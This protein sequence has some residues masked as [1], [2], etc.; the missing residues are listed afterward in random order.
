M[1]E[2]VSLHCISMVLF[3][4]NL[5]HFPPWIHTFWKGNI[6]VAL[7]IQET[8][9]EKQILKLSITAGSGTSLAFFPGG[10]QSPITSFWK[11]SPPEDVMD[12]VQ[13]TAWHHL[14][15]FETS[16]GCSSICCWTERSR[17]V[18]NVL[19]SSCQTEPLWAQQRKGLIIWLIWLV[20]S[21]SLLF[22]DRGK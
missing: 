6:T 9:I 20:L 1:I 18:F 12:R 14:L 3:L 11:G 8:K 21:C 5:Y 7:E 17:C 4:G 16:R 10:N 2:K 22:R 15:R 19:K 13:V